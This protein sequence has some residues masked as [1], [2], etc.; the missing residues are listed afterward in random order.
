MKIENEALHKLF[1][2]QSEQS[3]VENTYYYIYYI[4]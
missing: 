4:L 1:L 2:Q 3:N